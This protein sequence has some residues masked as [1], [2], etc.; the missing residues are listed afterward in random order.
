MSEWIDAKE[1]VPQDDQRVIACCGGNVFFARYLSSMKAWRCDPNESGM[2]QWVT[3][4]M[5]IPE[6]PKKIK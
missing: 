1:M 2:D 3:H 4:W 6:L 5:P